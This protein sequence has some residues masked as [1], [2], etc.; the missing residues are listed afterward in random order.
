MEYFFKNQKMGGTI[1]HPPPRPQSHA[2]IFVL[3]I[4]SRSWQTGKKERKKEIIKDRV[5]QTLLLAIIQEDPEPAEHK[6]FFNRINLGHTGLGQY[7]NVKRLPPDCLPT[8]DVVWDVWIIFFIFQSSQRHVHTHLVDYWSRKKTAVSVVI[9]RNMLV[10]RRGL[11]IV[12]DNFASLEKSVETWFL[13]LF[14]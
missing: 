9:S 12:G 1:P 3:I 8:L 13:W 14:S 11:L 6:R 2:K 4:A 5:V 7:S 10:T